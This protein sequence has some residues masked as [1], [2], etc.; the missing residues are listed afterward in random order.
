MHDAA[1]FATNDPFLCQHDVYKN[2]VITFKVM[3]ELNLILLL[4]YHNSAPK[5]CDAT[6]TMLCDHKQTRFIFGCP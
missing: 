5:E 6:S 4:H 2:C 1:L 3:Q